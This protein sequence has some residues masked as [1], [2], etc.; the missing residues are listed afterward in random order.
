MKTEKIFTRVQHLQQLLDRFLACR[1]TEK[2]I[3]PTSKRSSSLRDA[4]NMSDFR[5]MRIIL[6]REITL[7]LFGLALDL[8][9]RLDFRMQGKRGKH[10]GDGGGDSGD[11]KDDH[12][13]TSAN[14]R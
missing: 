9:E 11:D 10:G 3:E 5:E 8:D 13:E 6:I 2:A 1:P 12:Q 4:L 7:L 14:I